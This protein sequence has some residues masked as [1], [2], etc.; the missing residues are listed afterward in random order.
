MHAA[1]LHSPYRR[2]EVAAYGAIPV[3]HD[4]SMTTRS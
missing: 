4:Q 2:R 3:I 1:T